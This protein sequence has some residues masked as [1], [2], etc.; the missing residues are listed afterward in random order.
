MDKMQVKTDAKRRPPWFYCNYLHS[1]PTAICEAGYGVTFW[2]G[3][4]QLWW[5]CSLLENT[6]SIRLATST[7]SNSLRKTVGATVS[8]NISMVHV[9]VIKLHRSKVFNQ[10]HANSNKWLTQ[11]STNIKCPKDLSCDLIDGRH[12]DH[13]QMMKRTDRCR[14]TGRTFSGGFMDRTLVCVITFLLENCMRCRSVLK[15][16]A[17]KGLEEVKWDSPL[18]V[19]GAFQ[20]HSKIL[21]I[22][23]Q[24]QPASSW[25]QL[26][27]LR[28]S[29]S[30]LS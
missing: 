17:F 30:Q 16:W 12:C 25:T 26:A 27:G 24:Y 3:F 23:F 21:S 28:W 15:P 22:H 4:R 13:D 2:F 10:R 18:K 5:R 1:C 14:E 7:T 29:L 8:L 20:V 6:K 11:K 19:P 9:T